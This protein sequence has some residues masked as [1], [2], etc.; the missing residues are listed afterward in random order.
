MPEQVEGRLLLAP[1]KLTLSLRVTGVRED[2]L[3]TLASEMVS[4]SLFD[5][6]RLFPSSEA[7][8]TEISM[9]DPLGLAE[10]GFPLAEVPL[11]GGNLIARAMAM[12][13][14]RGGV[15][16]VKRIP[17]GAGL[18]GGSSDAAAVL[19]ALLPEL[20]SR[21]ALALGSDVPFCVSLTRSMVKGVGDE[22][23]P[24]PSR[25]GR[26]VLFLIPL[27]SPTGAVY[28]AYDQGARGDFE[29]SG[30]DL[31]EAAIAVT[32]KL[33][34]YREM[35]ADKIGVRPRMAGSGST[36]FAEGSLTGLGLDGRVHREPGTVVLEESGL[37]CV[38]VE[39]REVNAL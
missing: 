24:L 34:R 33:A 35:I 15:E 5:E 4:V 9:T 38:A 7:A 22:I 14:V 39:V 26:W 10:L 1:A 21:A 25:D 29:E 3:H 36:Y 6:L 37:R 27:H 17:P 18:G 28:G 19:R 8:E 12:A 20:D 23:E 31:E 13:G 2:G 30:N 11:G 16:L 32:P